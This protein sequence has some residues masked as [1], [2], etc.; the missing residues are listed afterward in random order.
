MEKLDFKTIKKYTRVGSYCVHT[1]IQYLDETIERYIK[2]YGCQLNPDFQRGHVWNESQQIS[3]VE[4]ILRGGQIQTLLF[5]HPHW[6]GNFD[7]DTDDMVLVDGLQRL[8]AIL[9]FLKNELPIFGGYK[10]DEIDGLMLGLFDIQISVNNLKTKKEVL[11]WYIE[12]NSGG[13]V[14]TPEEIEKVKQL[15]EKEK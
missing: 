6:M 3:F 4:F 13:T 15:I 14:H 9:K 7:H 12:L 8:T 1:S 10:R 5:N 2:T 11:Q